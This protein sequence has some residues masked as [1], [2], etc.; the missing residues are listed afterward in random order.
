MYVP[1]T[2]KEDRIEVLHGLIRSNPF[3]LLISNGEDGPSATAVPFHLIQDGS[4]FGV[5]QAHIA[6]ANPH[7]QNIDGQTV[8]IIFQG[9]NE[10]ISPNWYPS[11]QMHGMVVPTW[12]YVMVQARGAVKVIE[13]STW[14]KRQ[15]TALTDQQEHARSQPWKVSDAPESYIDA[16]LKHIIGLEIVVKQLEGKWKVSQN[17]NAQDRKGTAENLLAEGKSEMSTLV[18]KYGNLEQTD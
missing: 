3:G 16:E 13:D 5:L 8:L 18:R 14:L 17:R 12:N 4:Q 15:I 10:Y 7:W 2:F 11:K 9:A 6:R 1:P